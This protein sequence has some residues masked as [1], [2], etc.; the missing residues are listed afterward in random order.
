MYLDLT[1]NFNLIMQTTT[2]CKTMTFSCKCSTYNALKL[3]AFSLKDEIIIA[4][5]RPDVICIQ[6][7]QQSYLCSSHLHE[8]TDVLAHSKTRV[9]NFQIALFL[10]HFRK[11]P[12]H[13]DR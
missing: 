13:E 7:I 9:A 12:A 4:G 8:N 6:D 2:N 3:A 5:A 10:I 1:R 11:A